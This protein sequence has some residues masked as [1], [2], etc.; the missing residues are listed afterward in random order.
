ML[1]RH[2]ENVLAQVQE[3]IRRCRLRA[4]TVRKRR[5]EAREDRNKA[6]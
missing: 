3:L 5:I 4:V 6:K 1:K 2:M